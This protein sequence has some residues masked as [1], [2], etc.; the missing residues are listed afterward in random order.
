MKKNYHA[1]ELE[2]L[3]FLADMPFADQLSGGDLNTDV[4]AGDGWLD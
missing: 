1:P 4:T 3:A 2:V